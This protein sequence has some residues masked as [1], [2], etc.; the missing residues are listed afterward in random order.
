MDGCGMIQVINHVAVMILA[1]Q[2][3]QGREAAKS[4]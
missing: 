2:K 3:H 4:G 1:V